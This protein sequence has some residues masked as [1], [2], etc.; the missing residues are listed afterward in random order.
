MSPAMTENLDYTTITTSKGDRLP[1][2]SFAGYHSSNV[3]LPSTGSPP[4]S[5]LFPTSGDQTARI[6][7]AL[8]SLSKVG[9]G[10]LLLAEG[11]F[12]LGSNIRIPTGT[13]LRGSGPKKTFLLAKSAATDLITLGGQVANPRVTPVTNITDTYV[14]IGASTFEVADA[15]K[16][17]VGQTIMVQR[18]VT[19]SWITAMGMA[20]LVRNGKQQTWI[21]VSLPR[22]S[23]TKPLADGRLV[24]WKDGPT[25]PDDHGGGPQQHNR[26][27]TT[28]GFSRLGVHAGSCGDLHAS[29]RIFRIGSR[30]SGHCSQPQLFGKGIER[31]DLQH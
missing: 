27:F 7:T 5:T 16:L 15:S 14:P 3:D 4:Q 20:D 1:D 13:V 11:N 9:G 31:Q 12:E 22:T 23:V 2:F 24:G 8:D 21:A 26:R 17:N 29:K 19:D 10:V 25:A 18:A 6:Q 28:H 30:E